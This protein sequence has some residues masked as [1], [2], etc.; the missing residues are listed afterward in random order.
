MGKSESRPS[1]VF[2]KNACLT[3]QYKSNETEAL[4]LLEE[5]I[6]RVWRRRTLCQ[7]RVKKWLVKKVAF[8]LGLEG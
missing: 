6:K 8:G 5:Q 4:A 7:G 3:H 2:Q 1:R